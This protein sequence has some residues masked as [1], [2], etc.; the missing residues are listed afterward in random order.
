[1][2][3]VV[4]KYVRDLLSLTENVNIF[5]SDNNKLVKNNKLLRVVVSRV[6]PIRGVASSKDYNSDTEIE[7]LSGFYSSSATIGF[8][9][10]G[11]FLEAVKFQSLQLSEE[12]GQHSKNNGLTI[13]HTGSILDLGY[14]HDQEDLEHYQIK[15]NFNINLSHSVSRLRIETTELLTTEDI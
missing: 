14:L 3:R 8:F 4:A 11:A 5:I 9:G 6:G 10:D 15:F 1:M 2:R 13:S 12:G 7:T